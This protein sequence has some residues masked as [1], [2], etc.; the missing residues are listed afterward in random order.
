MKAVN[1]V[2]ASFA[3]PPLAP[4]LLLFIAGCQELQGPAWSPDGRFLAFTSYALSEGEVR[5]SVW[6]LRTEEEI[7]EPIELARNAAFPRWSPDGAELCFLGERNAHGFFTAFLNCSVKNFKADRPPEALLRDPALKLAALQVASEGRLALLGS[8]REVRPGA[9]LTLELFN[10]RDRSRSPL[11]ELGEVCSPVFRGSH[12]CF[13]TPASAGAK[14]SIQTVD[15]DKK[16]YQPAKLFPLEDLDEPGA[17]F[18]VLHAAPNGSLLLFYAP[19]GKQ[20]WI[21]DQENQPKRFA[22]PAEHTVPVMVAW[23]EQGRSAVLTLGRAGASGL[24]FVVFRLSFDRG[25]WTRVDEA[26]ELLGGHVAQPGRKACRAWLSPAS[27]ALGEPGNTRYFPRSAK[28]WTNASKFY[29][30]QKQ[31]DLAL[32]AMQSARKLAPPPELAGELHWVE[33]RLLLAS[34]NGA[35]AATAAERAV[36]LNP[37]GRWGVPYLFRPLPQAAGAEPVEEPRDPNAP[38]G[39]P[40]PARAD[41]TALLAQLK[42]FIAAAPENKVLPLLHSGLAL[43]LAGKDGASEEYRKLEQICPSDDL[44]CGARF[45]QGVTAL[46]AGEVAAAGERFAAAAG[47]AEFPWADRAAGLGALCY[48]LNGRTGDL[49]RVEAAL[50]AGLALDT[51]L[52]EELKQLQREAEGRKWVQLTKG[53]TVK[54]DRRERE[55]WMEGAGF[56]LPQAFTRP[57]RVLD[58]ERK[59]VERRVTLTPAVRTALKWSEKGGEAKTALIVPRAVSTPVFSPGGEAVAFF[60]EGDVTPQPEAFA[61]VFAATL[62]GELLVG[63]KEVLA[64]GPLATRTFLQDCVWTSPRELR[65]TGLEM[66]P[67]GQG[68]AFSRNIH[69]PPPT[70]PAKKGVN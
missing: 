68:K 50:K 32:S 16:P 9:P 2:R 69:V 17:R 27:L 58:A 44:R 67:F 7:G 62:E 14:S 33:A 55:A 57:T 24:R 38:A 30:A 36:L 10:L 8:A 56:L 11:P 43:R 39:L 3:R 49:A 63:S 60:V 12:L 18:Y 66:D 65:V 15:L 23:E 4:I 6:L 25:D 61:A 42:I 29:L 46:E 20:V 59:V 51:P 31:N 52:K 28:E 1:F 70:P 53:E 48:A 54:S 37:L 34:G 35:Q 41:Q 40:S 19:E 45:L 47:S 21:L 64:G 26:E 22:L 13:S 5:T